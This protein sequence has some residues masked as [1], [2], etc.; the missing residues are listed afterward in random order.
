MVTILSKR[1]TRGG[2]MEYIIKGDT[3]VFGGGAGLRFSGSP[4]AECFP[5]CPRRPPIT[6]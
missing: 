4:F 5:E 1:L 2:G 6:V 3:L